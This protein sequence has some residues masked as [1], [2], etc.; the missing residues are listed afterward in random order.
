MKKGPSDSKSCGNRKRGGQ[1]FSLS[2]MREGLFF[3]VSH[4]PEE[5]RV[6]DFSEK[7]KLR[8]F[9]HCHRSLAVVKSGIV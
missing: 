1:E 2:P 8:M 7:N 9:L 5:K 3:A 4:F 6:S